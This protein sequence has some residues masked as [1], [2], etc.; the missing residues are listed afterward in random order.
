[1]T[2]VKPVTLFKTWSEATGEPLVYEMDTER[3]E[4]LQKT[5]NL[6]RGTILRWYGIIHASKLTNDQGVKAW[7]RIRPGSHFLEVKDPEEIRALDAIPAM[8]PSSP[9]A[10]PSPST[11]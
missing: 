7:Y 9:S 10:A 1:M 4:K 3:L 8:E 6:S 5:T 11:S 2:S